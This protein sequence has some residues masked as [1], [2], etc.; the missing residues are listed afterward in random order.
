MPN[1][2]DDLDPADDPNQ[3]AAT[4]D[5]QFV[6][7]HF[8]ETVN[9]MSTASSGTEAAP[10]KELSVPERIGRY[11]IRGVLGRGAFG[12]VYRGYDSQ[13]AREVA[14]KVP[15]LHVAQATEASFLDE[16]RQLAQLAHPSIVTVHDIGVEEGLCYIVSEYLPGDDLNH[17]LKDRE[18]SWQECVVIVASI[19]DAL[20]SAHAAGTIHRDIKPANIIM[21]PR[22]NNFTPVLVDFG[23]AVSEA[24]ATS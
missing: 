5:S 14:I 11:E 18:L 7:N 8:G 1:E 24:T 21:T 4:L 3:L 6:V 15:L 2:E 12:A 22:A 17:W 10:T 16:A 20:D 9:Y 19:L 23:L 13:L